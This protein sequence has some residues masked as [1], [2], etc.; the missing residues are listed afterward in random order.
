MAWSL[1]DDSSGAPAAYGDR[2]FFKMTDGADMYDQGDDDKADVFRLERALD[3]PMRWHS[4]IGNMSHMDSRRG[5]IT[6]S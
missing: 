5:W 6:L 4:T 3:D 1:V 2:S